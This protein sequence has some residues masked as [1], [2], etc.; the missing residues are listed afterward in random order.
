M[1]VQIASD[2]RR[3]SNR[4]LARPIRALTN[5]VRAGTAPARPLRAHSV[6]RTPQR[7]AP[8]SGTASSPPPALTAAPR[9]SARSTARRADAVRTVPRAQRPSNHQ[10]SGAD[11]SKGSWS[12]GRFLR[13]FMFF[14]SP[15][16]V[17]KGA[18]KAAQ[19]PL[20]ALSPDKVRAFDSQVRKSL[21][22]LAAP[23]ALS[24]PLVRQTS[25]L[26]IA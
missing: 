6:P 24:P 23:A 4:S 20:R 3:A 18:I 14:N 2:D 15:G 21:Q 22:L 26:S 19:S 17:A 11:A 9:P 16:D 7:T 12:I 13:T 5:L 8:R 10:K 25:H 1:T